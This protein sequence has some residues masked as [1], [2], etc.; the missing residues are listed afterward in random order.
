MA[1]VTY[2]LVAG[3]LL[4]LNEKFSPE[5]L[6][7][8]AS[9]A[10]GW[11]LFEIIV[12]FISLYVMN[13]SS[14]I[15]FFHVMALSGYKFVFMITALL[16]NLIFSQFGYYFVLLYSSVSLGFFLLRSLHIT[17]ETNVS[18]YDHLVSSKNTLYLSIAFC[19]FQPISMYILTRHLIVCKS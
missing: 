18:N 4:G 2:I 17:I 15:G 3:Y 16:I 5:Q 13:L 19:L 11:F 14:A 1:F 8:Q 7:I 6:G 9:S 10:L 12:A